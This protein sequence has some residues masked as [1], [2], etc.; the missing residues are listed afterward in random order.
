MTSRR[1]D[2]YDLWLISQQFDFEGAVLRRAITNTF[3]NRATSLPKDVPVVLSDG[4]AEANAQ[5]W[6][7]FLNTFQSR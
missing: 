3:E 7:A 1:K 5:Q 4:Y 2:F 6:Q